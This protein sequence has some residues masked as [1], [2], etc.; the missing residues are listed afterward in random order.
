[1]KNII[2]F[3]LF[4]LAMAQ[5]A[6]AKIWRINN[7]TGVNAD[8]N[9]FSAAVTSASVVNGDTLYVEA[10][11]NGYGGENV[12]KK[13]TIIGAGYFLSETSPLVANPKTQAN[14]NNS[15]LNYVT[16]TGGSKGSKIVGI[17]CPYMYIDDSLITIERNYIINTINVNV[18]NNT[19][20]DTIRQ[21]FIGGI[22]SYNNNTVKAE[23]L[24]IYNNIFTGFYSMNFYSTAINYNSGYFLNNTCIYYSYN[25]C[26]NFVFQN[27]ILRNPNFDVYLTSNVFF[28]CI[29]NGTTLPNTNGNKLSVDIDNTVFQGYSDGT[30]FSSDGRYQLKSGSPALAAGSQNGNTVDCGAFG[31][32]A[33][34]VLSGMPN[35][36]SI[37]TL[38]VPTQINSSAVTMGVSLS[39]ASH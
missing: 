13:L 20:A 23:N 34:Y 1:M 19:Y 6:H 26:I 18:N 14:I 29:D 33:P 28:N 22:S 27:D 32:V 2:T 38:T 7:I 9:S 15:Y 10:S 37:Y 36:P 31:G 30:G 25:R 39:S 8:F 4:L 21:N 24:L 5:T 17:V 3:F 35:I 16:F 12:A 11:A